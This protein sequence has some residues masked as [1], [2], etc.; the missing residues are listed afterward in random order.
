[1]TVQVRNFARVRWGLVAVA[2]V[3]ALFAGSSVPA[4][5]DPE[6]NC[7][8][9][10]WQPYQCYPPAPSA[11]GSNGGTPWV[12]VSL[13]WPGSLP[14][15]GYLTRSGQNGQ[16]LQ[17]YTNDGGFSATYGDAQVTAGQSYTY[18]VCAVYNLYDA[19]GNS[20]GSDPECAT[21]TAAVP[22]TPT[23]G[24]HAGGGG[25]PAGGGSG[26]SGGGAGYCANG[27]GSCTVAP[28]VTNVQLTAGIAQY[29]GT[30]WVTYQ[31]PARMVTDVVVVEL[32]PTVNDFPAAQNLAPNLSEKTTIDNLS[33]STK[34][35]VE[36]CTILPPPDGGSL[37]PIG[38]AWTCVGSNIVTTPPPPPQVSNVIVKS[39]PD[40]PEIEVAWQIMSV[41]GAHDLD[42]ARYVVPQSLSQS[43]NACEVNQCTSDRD[44]YSGTCN[45]CTTVPISL[46]AMDLDD[47][48][49]TAGTYYQYE[50]CYDTVCAYSQP[51]E[52]YRDVLIDRT[53]PVARLVS[54]LVQ[55]T[56]PSN[57]TVTVRD[58]GG[59]ATWS[60]A[61]TSI[62]SYDVEVFSRRTGHWVGV[63]STAQQSLSFQLPSGFVS[64]GQETFQ[65]CAVNQNGRTCSAS[66]HP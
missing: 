54:E 49:V 59:E 37:P 36:I 65:V 25:G 34:V 35:G 20:L 7:P 11:S 61:D 41:A 31:T 28:A 53:V 64:L 33:T 43:A 3:V 47:T 14:D 62:T 26:G 55:P 58:S 4:H 51:V 32:Q 63:G 52:T 38:N 23:S 45:G 30:A 57:V 1:M 6:G 24:G 46:S 22:S 9:G 48:S 39:N 16:H 21:A 2:L 19:N 15:S 44:W 10:A 29:A 17:D 60:D 12:T 66:V 42:I 18:T 27:G 5:A 8:N 56:E 40:H 13:G 50:V